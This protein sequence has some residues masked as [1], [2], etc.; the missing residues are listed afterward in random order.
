MEH[1][2]RKKIQ[3]DFK[4]KDVYTH[5][6]LYVIENSISYLG[7]LLVDYFIY[8]ETIFYGYLISLLINVEIYESVI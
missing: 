1:I 2:Y 6:Y 3:I 7:I 4:Q 5:S 8:K